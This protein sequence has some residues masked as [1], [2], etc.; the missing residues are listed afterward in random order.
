MTGYQFDR[1]PR[2]FDIEEKVKIPTGINVP[3]TG[4]YLAELTHFL[5]CARENRPSTRVSRQ[6]VLT[7]IQLLEAVTAQA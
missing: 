5:D 6:Q 1:E 7:V 4:T 3:P 2:A